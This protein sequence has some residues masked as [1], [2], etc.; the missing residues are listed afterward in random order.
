MVT[1]RI[2]KKQETLHH[3]HYARKYITSRNEEG[4]I[5]IIPQPERSDVYLVENWGKME[6]FDDFLEKALARILEDKKESDTGNEEGCGKGC[7]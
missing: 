5:L 4:N 3:V 7:S 2:P 1:A 6:T